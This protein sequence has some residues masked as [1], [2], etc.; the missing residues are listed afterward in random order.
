V[1]SFGSWADRISVHLP[2]DVV[3]TGTGYRGIVDWEGPGWLTLGLA[4]TVLAALAVSRARPTGSA[5]VVA[6]T[7]FGAEALTSIYNAVALSLWYQ[8]RY[9]SY[10][11]GWG[12][13]LCL[14][15]SVLGLAL[16]TLWVRDHEVV[17][18]PIGV[19]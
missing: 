3:S 6:A 5:R 16:A 13:W 1:G 12:L 4:V 14:T 8:F 9:L 11:I 2:P 15:C 18:T 10:S 17:R 7:L 19:R